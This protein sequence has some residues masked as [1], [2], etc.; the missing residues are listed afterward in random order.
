[1]ADTLVDARRVEELEA[2]VAALIVEA[3]TAQ[4]DADRRT[5]ELAVINT[6]QQAVGAA[7]DFQSIVDVVGDKLR[8]VFAT[9]NLSIWWQ[10]V[11]GGP[12]RA[13]YNFEHGANVG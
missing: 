1:M 3:R 6:T 11:P 4:A 10:E 8:E 9:G 12:T 7:L 5:A 13:L 2:E